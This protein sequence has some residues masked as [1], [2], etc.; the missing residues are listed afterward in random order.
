MAKPPPDGITTRE[1]G[2][3]DAAAV[4]GLVRA[5]FASWEWA[6]EWTPNSADVEEDQI[7]EWLATPGVWCLLATAGGVPAGQ[8][9]LS[10]AYVEDSDPPE[11]IPGLCHLRH[12]FLDPAW[13][14]TGLA[15][16]LLEAAM[17]RARADGYARARLWTPRDNARARAFYRRE[18]WAENGIERASTRFGMPLVQMARELA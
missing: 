9:T 16:Y 12:L 4:A 10:P 11:E 17:E 7:A 2:P 1:A 15:A 6:G 5:G 13:H 18:G 3:R 8:T 14:G